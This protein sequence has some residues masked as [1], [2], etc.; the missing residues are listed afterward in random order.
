MLIGTKKL[1]N[2]ALEMYEESDGVMTTEEKRELMPKF[3]Y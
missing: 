2:R 3:Y 1:M